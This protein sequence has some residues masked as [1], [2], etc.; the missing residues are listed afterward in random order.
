VK[1][2]DDVSVVNVR[3][4]RADGENMLAFCWSPAAS[5]GNYGLG[6]AFVLY[7][8]ITDSQKIHKIKQKR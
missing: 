1:Y 8:R 6:N 7:I 3:T 2:I 4:S 5:S